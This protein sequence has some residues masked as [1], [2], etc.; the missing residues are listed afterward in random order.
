[1]SLVH[2][3]SNH[4]SNQKLIYELDIAENSLSGLDV[5]YLIIINL[6]DTEINEI[7]VFKTNSSILDRGYSTEI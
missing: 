1:M 3:Y 7:D 4:H 2:F 5:I 6:S